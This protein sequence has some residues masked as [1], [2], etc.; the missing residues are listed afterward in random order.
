MDR[1][2]AVEI[3]DTAPRRVRDFG[4][5]VRMAAAAIGCA[6]VMLVAVFMRGLAAGVE[7]DVHSASGLVAWLGDLPTLMIS[8]MATFAVVFSV[9][10]QIVMAREWR[11]AVSA[12][13]AL[14]GGYAIAAIASTLIGAF[15]SDTLV[16][17]LWSVTSNRGP[18]LPDLYAG[19]AAFLTAAGPKRLRST[20]KWGW[21]VTYAVAVILVMLNTNSLSGVL[22]SFLLGRL[23][24][25]AV[26]L[27]VGTQNQGV[28]GS[29]LADA[30]EGLGLKPVTLVRRQ[31]RRHD[32][33][34][35]TATLDDDL[36]DST[37]IYDLTD[38]S[39]RTYVVSVLDAQAHTSGYLAQVWQ[40]LKLSGASVRR[41]RS[42]RDS[43][44]HHQAMLLLL[45][46][47]GL[48]AMRPYAI[49]EQSES[50]FLVF[51][52]SARLTPLIRTGNAGHAGGSAIDGACMEAYL[53]YLDAA[54][55]RGIT[56]RS[57]TP[58][59]LA[60][61]ADGTNTPV[62]AGWQTGDAAS[63][64]VNI[65]IDRVQLLVLLATLG[66]TDLA[67]AAARKVWPD[68]RLVDLV[69]FVQPVAVPKAT[70]SLPQWRKR[71]LDD[72][73]AGLRA[74]ADEEAA[75]ALPTV[76]LSRFSVRSFVATA[77]LVVAL[78]VIVTQLNMEQV[79]E[80]VRNANPWMAA[81][82]FAFGCL[83]WVASGITLGAFIDRE[84]R[85]PAGIFMSQAAS[86][87]AS[88]SMPAGVGPAFVNLQY[89]RRIG[90]RGPQ[91]TAVMS[92]VLALQVVATCL[93]I[94]G[95]GVFTGRNTFSGMVPTNTLVI[96]VSAV[97][98][99]VVAA[100]AV[101]R[102]RRLVR[103]RVLPVVA[104]YARQ[105]A[106]LLTRP[107]QLT[108]GAIG[109]ILQSMCFGLSFWAALMAFGWQSNVFE[110]TFVFLLA[111][112]LGSAVP[113]PGGL[114]A[115]EAA[116]MGGFAA[117]GIP[118]AVALS[119]TLLYRLVTYWL[120]IPLGAAAM[121]W[122]SRRNLV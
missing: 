52:G 62:I 34:A 29:A 9:L 88:V 42:V 84:R 51:D 36:V 86:S 16:A 87:F 89:L 105:L 53:R 11:Q 118:S 31:D 22:L 50:A 61:L 120:R 40:W 1:Q 56:H 102:V 64:A 93:L 116:L 21:N 71:I 63:S 110:T 15:G 73:R 103:E 58:A 97:V 55:R 7:M 104:A 17:G 12:P 4:D 27:A 79:I 35:L 41:D 49:A 30:L 115:V 28:W 119:A 26:R 32:P 83:T 19:M 39:G 24:G 94:V 114:G 98:V 101:P 95:I 10:I 91:A 6:A 74:L 45:A 48:P 111:N 77:L 67:I 13:I 92:A 106:D 8:Q 18:L 117:T 122:L 69:P 82:S 90:Y 68:G 37:R 5:L 23:V 2:S 14:V 57:I 47:A 72:L 113:T 25:L 107:R 33:N 112:S 78:A 70:R 85:D 75:D 3:T 20:V 81:L 76:T 96:V 100:M 43:V 108:V 44:Q 59:C 66:G 46:N 121:E 38:D 109:A 60:Q 54:H 99:I 80:A 65:A